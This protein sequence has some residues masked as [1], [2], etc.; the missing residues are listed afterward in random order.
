[1]NNLQPREKWMVLAL[2]AVLIVLIYYFFSLRGYSD[3]MKE[4]RRQEGVLL[5]QQPQPSDLSAKLLKVSELRAEKKELNPFK[6]EPVATKKKKEADES[7]EEARREA[8]RFLGDL[9]SGN[10]VIVIDESLAEQGM[11]SLMKPVLNELPGA[12]LW[13]LKVAGRYLDI[14]RVVSAVSESSHALFVGAV[15]MERPSNAESPVKSWS[16]WVGR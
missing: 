10:E 2:P 4:L 16:L 5:S 11:S 8:S 6:K 15:K 13:H 14:S 9:L 3:D 1:M 7:T 12:E